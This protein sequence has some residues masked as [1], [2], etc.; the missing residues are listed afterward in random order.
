MGGCV[1]V[2]SQKAQSTPHKGRFGRFCKN[3]G[4]IA[5]SIPDECMKR[6]SDAGSHVTDIAV[7]EYV[8]K[9]A[10]TT[11]NCKRSEL[12]HVAFHLTQLQWNHSQIDANGFFIYSSLTTKFLIY[13]IYTYM[14]MHGECFSHLCLLG[15]IFYIF[16]SLLKS[17]QFVTVEMKLFC[18]KM[19]GGSMVR[20][21]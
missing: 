15:D 21:C 13:I 9:G 12:S 7:S 20:F 2:H 3:R 8:Q 18:R 17:K 11:C 16:P 5:T 6:M 4:K 14:H 10:S 19:P 1:S